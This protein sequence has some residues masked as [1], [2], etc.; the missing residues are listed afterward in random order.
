MVRRRPL[1]MASSAQAG[2]QAPARAQSAGAILAATRVPPLRVF[3]GPADP[4]GRCGVTRAPA[5]LSGGVPAMAPPMAPLGRPSTAAS[6][7]LMVRRPLLAAATGEARALPG[8]YGSAGSAG[9]LVR[10]APSLHLGGVPAMAPPTADS[11]TGETGL[12][13]CSRLDGGEAS[14]SDG[15]DGHGSPLGAGAYSRERS[16]RSGG[17]DGLGAVGTAPPP[18]GGAARGPNVGSEEKAGGFGLRASASLPSTPAATPAGAGVRRAWG[19]PGD[20]ASRATERTCGDSGAAAGKPSEHGGGGP[21]H[22]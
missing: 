18:H 1:V 14:H 4:D 2:C 6:G 9:A 7:T 19:G 15:G 13:G 10:R 16:G 17:R 8:A 22:F 5:P 11:S 21:G 12:R 3:P 20:G